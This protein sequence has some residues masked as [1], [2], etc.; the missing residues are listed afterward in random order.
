MT[1]KSDLI[2]GYSVSLCVPN[3]KAELGSMEYNLMTREIEH[4][5]REDA[6]EEISE[7]E[8]IATTT[9]RVKCKLKDSNKL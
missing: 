5:S 4:P 8:F 2:E 7:G 6:E 1:D 9:G 3:K